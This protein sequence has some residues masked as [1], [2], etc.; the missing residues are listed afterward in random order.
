[1]VEKAVKIAM[2][3]AMKDIPIATIVCDG[4]TYIIS[5]VRICRNCKQS[6]VI[7]DGNYKLVIDKENRVAL[8]EHLRCPP[9]PDFYIFG[10]D[11]FVM[12]TPEEKQNFLYP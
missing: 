10:D 12:L 8:H 11:N 5:Q 9:K 3:T 7:T 1:M 4:E 2:T 6:L